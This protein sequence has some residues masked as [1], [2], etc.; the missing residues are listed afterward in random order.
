MVGPIYEAYCDHDEDRRGS[1]SSGERRPVAVGHFASARCG[2]RVDTT[3]V[4]PRLRGRRDLGAR[5][6]PQSLRS[7]RHRART[8]GR[9]SGA[10]SCARAIH[11]D[12]SGRPRPD[13]SRSSVACTRPQ[14]R[15]CTDPYFRP[16][17]CPH[18]YPD[19]SPGAYS[20]RCP[21]PHIGANSY[22]GVNSRP[23]ANSHSNANSH[24]DP[25]SH[26][27]ANSHPDANSH[28]PTHG[29][30]SSYCHA[31]ARIPA[32]PQ[33]IPNH[34]DHDHAVNPERRGH[35]LPAALRGRE[36]PSGSASRVLRRS[37]EVRAHYFN[38]RRRLRLG[39]PRAGIHDARPAHHSAGRTEARP[40]P[41]SN[42][43]ANPGPDSHADARSNS[44]AHADAD[45]RS[46]SHAH[47]DARSN[48][49][50]RYAHADARSDS[51]AYARADTDSNTSPAGVP[52]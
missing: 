32:F 2:H 46:D 4:Y 31:L 9:A 1:D 30:E 26:P 44:Y 39:Q 50:A 18:S 11:P 23:N 52:G 25:N 10:S 24:P 51:Y 21:D 36:I 20:H 8:G 42:S 5:H 16:Y 43:H 49:D 33:R 22:A 35:A 3:G 45:A 47:P 28:S 48:P 14:P 29:N 41:G 40:C 12:W 34:E 7:Q 27:G 38:P 37:H 19:R 17:H 15:S 6:G 13:R